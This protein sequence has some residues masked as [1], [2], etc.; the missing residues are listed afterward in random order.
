MREIYPG[1]CH[2]YISEPS[3][4]G[5][6]KLLKYKEKKPVLG[7]QLSSDFFL[8]VFEARRQGSWILKLYEKKYF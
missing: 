8:K 6:Q 4:Q 5:T 1:F 3:G 7:I 2:Q